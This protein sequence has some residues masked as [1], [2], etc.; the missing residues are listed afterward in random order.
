MCMF[1]ITL[2]FCGPPSAHKTIQIITLIH[3]PI[4]HLKIL[5]QLIRW[6]EYGAMQ[7]VFVATLKL[8]LLWL[9]KHS[10][11]IYKNQIEIRFSSLELTLTSIVLYQILA[12]YLTRV[13]NMTNIHLGKH[14]WSKL[15]TLQDWSI[16]VSNICLGVISWIYWHTVIH[17]NI[18]SYMRYMTLS[19]SG[20]TRAGYMWKNIFVYSMILAHERS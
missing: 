13:V 12:S 8:T 2:G 19:E 20:Q 7:E 18:L 14:L 17:L 1:V 16:S 9:V 5:G 11:H 4:I 3:M 15:S 10:F 6:N